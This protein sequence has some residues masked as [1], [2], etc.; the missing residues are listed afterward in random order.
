MK[1]NRQP[2]SSSTRTQIAVYHPLT[3]HLERRQQILIKQAP[4]PNSPTKATLIE[5]ALPFFCPLRSQ[6]I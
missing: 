1:K 3:P 4:Y 5:N 2:R 6:K